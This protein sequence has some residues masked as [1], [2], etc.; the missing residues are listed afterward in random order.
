MKNTEVM[1]NFGILS[2]Q[3]LLANQVRIQKKREKKSI[4]INV[5]F[6]FPHTSTTEIFLKQVCKVN[7]YTPRETFR[8]DNTISEKQYSSYMVPVAETEE[9]LVPES[10]SVE[11][12]KDL[13]ETEVTTKSFLNVLT[14]RIASSHKD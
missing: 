7:M 12:S 6:F 13:P 14:L 9:I 8:E 11:G 4:K 1:L 10:F 5:G 3:T 2:M